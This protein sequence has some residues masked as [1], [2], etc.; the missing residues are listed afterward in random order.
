MG[1]IRH[2]AMCTKN[3]RRLARFYNRVFGTQEVWNKYQNSPYSRDGLPNGVLL[4]T[5]KRVLKT[6]D[7]RK[8]VLQILM[9]TYL[10]SRK[11]PGTPEPKST[12]LPSTMSA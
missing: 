11:D 9:A 4:S 8:G 5:S 1:E 3:N 12:S 7:M 10:S 6:G 2:M